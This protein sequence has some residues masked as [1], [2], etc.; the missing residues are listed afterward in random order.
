MHNKHFYWYFFKTSL[1]S[2]W[3]GAKTVPTKDWITV[4][5]APGSKAAANSSILSDQMRRNS[6]SFGCS[7]T[8][9]D[10]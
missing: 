1:P 7:A 9:V 10:S 8:G 4:I 3:Y 2:E 5:D 6:I